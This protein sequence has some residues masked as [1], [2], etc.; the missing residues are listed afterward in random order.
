MNR[1]QLQWRSKR[2][3]QLPDWLTFSGVVGGRGRGSPQG[4]TPAVMG[5]SRCAT[6]AQQTTEGPDLQWEKTG[7]AGTEAAP[8]NGRHCHQPHPWTITA[9]AGK[10][11][12]SGS[13]DVTNVIP[14]LSTT[15]TWYV[16][17]VLTK[18]AGQGFDAVQDG[19]QF[20]R[21]A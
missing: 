6:L 18:P 12:E 16:V 2:E 1:V 11:G 8:R 5:C 13:S 17:I 7:D 20:V 10:S 19:T 14:K 21:P 4:T 9:S 15:Y 3:G